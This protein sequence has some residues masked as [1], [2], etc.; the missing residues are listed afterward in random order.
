MMN[1]DLALAN[2]IIWSGTDINSVPVGLIYI[3]CDRCDCHAFEI[4]SG[5]KSE[6]YKTKYTSRELKCVNCG[7]RYY[8]DIVK[9]TIS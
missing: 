5:Y 3:V 7:C 2:Y 6:G 1:R 9:R 4:L 8:V